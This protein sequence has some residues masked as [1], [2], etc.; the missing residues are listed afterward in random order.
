[1][2]PDRHKVFKAL[3][4]NNIGRC[5]EICIP[6]GVIGKAGRGKVRLN[7]GDRFTFVSRVRYRVRQNYEIMAAADVL[8]SDGCLAVM[9]WSSI[10][11]CSP[12]NAIKLV[13]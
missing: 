11:V 5:F 4:E 9:E 13:T 12:T 2:E 3:V 10:A 8:T 7:K 6:L 1:M